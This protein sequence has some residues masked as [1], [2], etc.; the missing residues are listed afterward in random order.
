MTHSS[1]TH[2]INKRR[3]ARAVRPQHLSDLKGLPAWPVLLSFY[4]M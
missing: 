2:S 4:R 1:M 3:T